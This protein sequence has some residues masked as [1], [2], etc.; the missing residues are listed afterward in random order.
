M[1]KRLT[2]VLVALGL[3]A[4]ESTFGRCCLI[5]SQFTLFVRFSGKKLSGVGR[6]VFISTVFSLQFACLLMAL[7]GRDCAGLNGMQNA[8]ASV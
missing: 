5:L 8:L 6:F 7:E 3:V 1:S 2:L 4:W